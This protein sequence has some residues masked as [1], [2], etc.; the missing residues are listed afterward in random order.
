MRGLSSPVPQAAGPSNVRPLVIALSLAAAGGIAIQA[1]GGG[2]HA[3]SVGQLLLFVLVLAALCRASLGGIAI[4]RW[5]WAPAVLTA[6]LGAILRHA[7]LD[8]SESAF[9][10]APL[11]QDT[12]Q[13]DTKILRDRMRDS[14]SHDGGVHIGTVSR[15]IGSAADAERLLH[16]D[17]SVWGVVWGTPRWMNVS[18]RMSPPISLAALPPESYA[19]KFLRERRVPDLAVAVSVPWLGISHAKLPATGHFLGSLAEALPAFPK[20]LV[21][22][23]D[24]AELEM[25][26]RGISALQAAWTS[27]AHRAVPFWMTGTYHLVRAVSGP[28]LERG[29]L[30]CALESFA[31]AQAQLLPGNNR[32][33]QIAIANNQ[34]IATLLAAAGEREFRG[35][36]REV[37][38]SWSRIAAKGSRRRAAGEQPVGLAVVQSNLKALR[39]GDGERREHR[40]RR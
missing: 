38:A 35:A 10:I 7:A 40:A 24:E 12:L 33:A 22:P 34:G 4:P 36:K 2:A 21:Q 37:S 27:N 30:K 29:E 31:R 23:R 8:V 19:R 18:L 6:S 1:F 3:R 28:Q 16:S 13:A 26:L 9:V 20:I 11:V 39:E 17:A 25:Q 14:A 5:V 15:L 32:E